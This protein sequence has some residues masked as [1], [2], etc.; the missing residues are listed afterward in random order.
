M[1]KI[2]AHESVSNWHSWECPTWPEARREAREWLRRLGRGPGAINRVASLGTAWV[3]LHDADGDGSGD[4]RVG[5]RGESIAIVD[6]L[7]RSV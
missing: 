4:E 2:I 7:G 1:I 3:D 6:A 5:W